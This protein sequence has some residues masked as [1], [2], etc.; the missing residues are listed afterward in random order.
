MGILFLVASALQHW[1]SLIY[2]DGFC[3]FVRFHSGRAGRGGMMARLRCA[4]TYDSENRAT[5]P[6]STALPGGLPLSIMPDL[7]W[8]QLTILTLC[9]N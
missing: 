3:T 1:D 6:P 2:C 5:M 9:L 4:V 8:D 7:P